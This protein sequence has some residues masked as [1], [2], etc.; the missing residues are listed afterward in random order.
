VNA[1]VAARITWSLLGLGVLLTVATLVLGLSR[2]STGKGLGSFPSD[3]IWFLSLALFIPMGALIT[4][5]H[6]GNPVGWI[7][8]GM[9]LAE[10]A[11]KFA[12]EYAAYSIILHPGSLPGGAAMAWL[13]TWVWS[14]ELGLFPF[15][16][17][18]FPNGRS[19][20]RRWSWIGWLAVAW[21]LLFLALALAMW[22]YRGA[23]L[24]LNVD[25][26]GVEQLA[27]FEDIV[28]ATFPVVMACLVVSLLSLIVRFRRSEGEE[29]QQLKWIAFVAAVGAVNIV[30]NDLILSPLGIE[31]PALQLIS[32]TIGGPGTFATAA[33]VAILK[34]RLYDIDLIINRTLVYGA[35]T[36]LLTLVYMGGV[37]GVGGLLNASTG[38]ENNSLVVAASTLTVAALFRPARAR[39]Q[40]FIDRR[41]YRRKYDATLT[42]EAFATRLRDE[43]E[44]D[45]L[46]QELVTVA[47]QTMQPTH[48]SLWLRERMK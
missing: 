19:L 40:A 29:R 8:L 48:A 36:I 46:S 18:L 9:G 12:F 10:T 37:V 24:L 11:S 34:Y 16:V 43:I 33:A 35:L 45:S 14:A 4:L 27:A 7:L 44:L 5:R 26:F 28:F 47:N 3:L 23:G 17:L 38:Q 32:E 21:M 39:I 13:S 42:L 22:P 25:S 31:S 15:M 30:V 41:F 1:R 6:P 20:S 2:G